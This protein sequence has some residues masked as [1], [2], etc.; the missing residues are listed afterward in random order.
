MT[1]FKLSVGNLELPTLFDVEV[2][3]VEVSRDVPVGLAHHV[4]RVSPGIYPVLLYVELRPIGIQVADFAAIGQGI[5]VRAPID[6]T[7]DPTQGPFLGE[8]TWTAIRIPTQGRVG[9]PSI[10]DYVTLTSDMVRRV[11]WLP[12]GSQDLHWRLELRT[13]PRQT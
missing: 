6:P 13:V 4:V 9:V 2:P 3:H 7:I 5:V 8:T 10:A 11:E 1:Q 12:D